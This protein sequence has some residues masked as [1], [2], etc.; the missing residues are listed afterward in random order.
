ML[1]DIIESLTADPRRPVAEAAFER[2]QPDARPS[3]LPSRWRPRCSPSDPGWALC[4][5]M[6]DY[7]DRRRQDLLAGVLR[8]RFYAGRFSSGETRL[9]PSFSAFRFWTAAT[10]GDLH[11]IRW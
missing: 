8:A 9:L 10:A 11:R 6:A 1:I 2:P 7:L 5:A 3:P 4:P